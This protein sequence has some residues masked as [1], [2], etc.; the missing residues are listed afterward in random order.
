MFNGFQLSNCKVFIFTI[1]VALSTGLSVLVAGQP[2]A[3]AKF[4][5]PEMSGKSVDKRLKFKDA[6]VDLV[7]R[8]ID[9]GED[10]IRRLYVVS[11]VGEVVS[12]SPRFTGKFMSFNGD[13]AFFIWGQEYAAIQKYAFLWYP[14]ESKTVTIKQEEN[15]IKAGA[16]SNGRYFWIQYFLVSAGKDA[17]KVC[18]YDERGAKKAEK[19]YTTQ[20]TFTFSGG[21]T[22]LSV[23]VDAPEF[24]Y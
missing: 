20:G 13:S 24:P 16:S 3:P 11:M 8:E 15:P 2:K 9:K 23:K 10:T 17:T 7:L 1:L 18:V 21:E 12:K 14:L 4:S 6:N 22:S 5:D 19:I